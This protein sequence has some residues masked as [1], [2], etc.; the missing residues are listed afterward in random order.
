MAIW[1]VWHLFNLESSFNSFFM[2]VSIGFMYVT[3][4]LNFIHSQ[5]W[6]LL[7]KRPSK[8]L[9]PYRWHAEAQK[10]GPLTRIRVT[11]SGLTWIT[12]LNRTFKQTFPWENGVTCHSELLNALNCYKEWKVSASKVVN[13]FTLCKHLIWAL[14]HRLSPISACD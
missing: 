11:G 10:M 7:L 5:L 4:G 1:D 12:Y 9:K 13:V 2:N 6:F 14:L 8:F 3:N